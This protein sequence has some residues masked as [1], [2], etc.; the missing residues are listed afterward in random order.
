ML[1]AKG[2][3][4]QSRGSLGLESE[5]QS[6]S[7]DTLSG[8]REAMGD[9]VQGAVSKPKLQNC[10]S[11]TELC[12]NCILRSLSINTICVLVVLILILI[13]ILMLMLS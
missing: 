3:R 6:S 7:D 10:R 5:L 13:L 9:L 4:S 11:P 2:V 12:R 8:S 1:N